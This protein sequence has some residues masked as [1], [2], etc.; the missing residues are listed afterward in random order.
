MVP[1]KTEVV[2]SVAD[3]PTCQKML[4]ASAPPARRTLIPLPT[5][6]F[7]AIWKIQTSVAL[8][9]SVTSDPVIRHPLVNL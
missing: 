4:A 6:R 7:D 1:L 8:P 2:P 3:A 9:V 5:M